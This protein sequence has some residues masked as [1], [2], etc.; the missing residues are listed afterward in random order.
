M[1]RYLRIFFLLLLCVLVSFGPL[2]SASG[3]RDTGG[4]AVNSPV[5]AQS[6]N[7]AGLV[8]V[9]GD[10]QVETRCV[11]FEPE[12]ISG[13]ELLQRSGLELRMEVAGM[14]PTICLIDGEGCTADEACFCRCQ[15]GPCAYW[16][17]WRESETGWRFSNIGAGSTA[18]SDGMVEGWVWGESKPNQAATVAPPDLTFAQVCSG[19]VVGGEP[20]ASSANVALQL[21]VGLLVVMGAPLVAGAVWWVIRRAKKPASGAA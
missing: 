18:I 5:S 17:Y 7:R 21:P 6:P 3:Q 14:G 20:A 19:E 12:S 4:F 1:P 15:S 8:V 13:Y 16:T 11:A 9:H 10:G 2:R